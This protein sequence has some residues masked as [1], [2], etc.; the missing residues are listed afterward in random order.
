MKK[1]SIILFSVCCIMSFSCQY[2]K[3]VKIDLATGL[4]TSY[5]GLTIDDIY[6]ADEN[7]NRLGDNKITMGSK[8]AVVA[9]GVDYFTEKDGKVFPG[10]SILLT[11]K[12]GEEIL[13]LPDAFADMVNGTTASEAKILQASLNTGDPMIVG[14]TYHLYVRFYDKNN[15]ENEIVANVDLLMKE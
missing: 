9:T 2:S 3:G 1:L 7:G 6:L 11:D 10:C 5:N 14:E 13:N 12:T 4:S 8:L 15:K